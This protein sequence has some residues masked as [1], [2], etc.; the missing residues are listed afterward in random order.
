MK[1]SHKQLRVIL[2][3]GV[4]KLGLFFKASKLGEFLIFD[5][6]FDFSIFDFSDLDNF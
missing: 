1:A 2:A 5:N 3:S 4:R 6:F